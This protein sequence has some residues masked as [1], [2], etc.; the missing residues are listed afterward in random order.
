M[1]KAILSDQQLKK[2]LK[3]LP[4]WGQLVVAGLVALFLWW[5]LLGIDKQQIAVVPSPTPPINQSSDSAVLGEVEGW[6]AIDRVVDGDTVRVLVD[7]K[8]QT[9]RLIGIDTPEVVDPRKPVQCFGQE[10][11]EAAKRLLS[12]QKVRLVVDETQGLVDRYQRWLR[13]IYLTD[14]R[15]VNLVLLQEGYA[16]EYTYQVPYI[17]QLAFQQAEQQARLAGRGLWSPT[18]CSSEIND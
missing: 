3:G 5:Q 10:A 8:S 4:W 6:F 13:Y 11:S 18:A 15:M 7:G 17:H 9:V 1:A 14:G 16:S 12:G 2:L